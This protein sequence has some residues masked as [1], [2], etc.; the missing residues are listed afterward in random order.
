MGAVTLGIDFL[1]RHLGHRLQ[2][3]FDLTPSIEGTYCSNC[4]RPVT[5][6]AEPLWQVQASWYGLP[7]A[8]CLACHVLYHPSFDRLGREGSRGPKPTALKLGMLRGCGALVTPMHS[9]LYAPKKYFPKLKAAPD[10]LFPEIV[11]LGGM[12][13]VHDVLGRL[14]HCGRPVLFIQNFGVKSDELTANLMVSYDAESLHVCSE[15]WVYELPVLVY[16][17]FE[18][19]VLGMP[20]NERTAW[21]ELFKSSCQQ[22]LTLGEIQALNTLTNTQAGFVPILQKIPVDPHVRMEIAQLTKSKQ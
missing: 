11:D 15:A 13:M 5:E 9:V 2:H 8:R 18:A 16:Q 7:V 21:L 10:P 4:H 19:H 3:E 6:W 17:Q 20:A 1:Y 14:T 22:P 12:A